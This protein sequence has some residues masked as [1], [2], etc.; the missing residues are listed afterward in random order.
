M[1]IQ[2][3]V[4]NRFLNQ[5]VTTVSTD[6]TALATDVII[7]VSNTASLRIITLP[8]PSALLVGKTFW[9]EDTSG[10]AS[11]NHIQIQPASG[12]IDGQAAISIVFNYGSRQIFCDGTTY[13]SL[14]SETAATP[15]I[16]AQ[17]FAASATYTPS[18][19]ML[20][21]EIIAVGGGGGGGG[22]VA[23]GATTYSGGGGGGSGEYAYGIFT[24]AQIG[25][26]QTITIGAAGSAGSG[27]AGG[28]GGATSVGSLLSANGGAG[29]TSASAATAFNIPGAL[30]GTGGTGGNF[31]FAGG[32]G[33]NSSGG[34]GVLFGGIGGSSEKGSGGQGGILSAGSA[35]LG[36][37][38]GGG[39]ASQVPSGAALA[40]GAGT[41]G[42]VFI[43]EYISGITPAKLVI[44]LAQASWNRQSSTQFT[45]GST[46]VQTSVSG[47]ATTPCNTSARLDLSSLTQNIG[48]GM[49]ISQ[50]QVA[51][52]R[53]GIYQILIDGGLVWL[54]TATN[55][56]LQLVKNGTTVLGVGYQQLNTSSPLSLCALNYTGLLAAG[57][58]IDVRCGA[59][60]SAGYQFWDV[61]FSI[62]QIPSSNLAPTT[63]W[64]A[65]PTISQ[66]MLPNGNYYTQNSSLTTMTLPVNAPSGS[67]LNIAG[68]GSGKW[69]LAQNANQSVNFE[70]QTTTTGTGG[71]I[72]AT[73][74]YDVLSLLCLTAN[75]QWVVT[76]G[77]GNFIVT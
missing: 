60:S 68:A 35:A 61:S 51:I 15:V 20:Y 31:R 69:T 36:Y 77:I 62:A 1:P 53:S 44:P 38:S 56:F 47:S 71:S 55:V 3:T 26:S 65:V 46:V 24:A 70:G 48:V 13:Y 32:V 27:V 29:G 11:T 58:T 37:G 25:T 57:D 72:A 54:V 6:Y 16:N 17:I 2:T 34:S 59:E 21:C 42:G 4:N 64:S 39:G 7:E 10:G 52:T 33:G 23:T 75:T 9:I 67:T 66:L 49:T 30:G 43:T 19:G 41:S 74:Q 28:A 12:T 8:T 5:P 40:G 63:L 50:F 45:P 73:N 76:S 18:P 22:A 14:S